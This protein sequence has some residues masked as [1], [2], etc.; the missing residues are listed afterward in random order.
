[1]SIEFKT[2]AVVGRSQ[3][4]RV[5]EPMALL[6]GYLNEAGV[7]VLTTPD[8]PAELPADAIDE[9]EISATAAGPSAPT[10]GTCAQ[11]P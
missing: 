9:A 5:A 1:M 8:T 7:R 6:A 2:V 11:R 4:L 10:P 3:D